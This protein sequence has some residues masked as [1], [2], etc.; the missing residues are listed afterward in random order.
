M[1]EGITFG[2]DVGGKSKKSSNDEVILVVIST[3]D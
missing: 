2:A 3:G 1:Y